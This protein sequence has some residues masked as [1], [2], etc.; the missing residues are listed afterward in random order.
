MDPDHRTRLQEDAAMSPGLEIAGRKLRRFSIASFVI[1]RRLEN[2]LVTGGVTTIQ[3]DGGTQAI[4]FS[5]PDNLQ[6]LLEFLYVHSA[7]IRDVLRNSKSREDLET[8]VLES[9]SDVS[10]P[11]LARASAFITAELE[12]ANASLAE[13]P[14]ESETDTE[15]DTDPNAQGPRG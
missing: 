6:A 15:E 8:A 13:V 11:E 7:P 14:P 3:S 1:L 10:T 9:M 2:R 12:Q 4:D 5:D